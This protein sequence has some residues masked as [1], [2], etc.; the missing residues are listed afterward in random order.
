MP[1]QM[2]PIGGAVRM[3]GR[4]RFRMDVEMVGAEEDGGPVVIPTTD[5]IIAMIKSGALTI[6]PSRM[7]AGREDI[8]NVPALRKDIQNAVGNAQTKHEL[9]ST[10]GWSSA[11]WD[12]M[13]KALLRPKYYKSKAC[14]PR[15]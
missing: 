14:F 7:P 4:G 15:F 5:G 2:V 3:L 12:T 13:V 1:E 10:G 6:H 11:A 8:E 9:S